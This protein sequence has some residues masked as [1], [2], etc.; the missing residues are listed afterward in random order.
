[1]SLRETE[2]VGDE[3]W[4]KPSYPLNDWVNSANAGF[5]VAELWTKMNSRVLISLWFPD[6]KRSIK[7]HPGNISHFSH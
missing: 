2:D 3:G 4:R 1:M 7:S 6:V 5:K